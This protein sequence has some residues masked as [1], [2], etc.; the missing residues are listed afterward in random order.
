MPK[1]RTMDANRKTRGADPWP[2]DFKQM[3]QVHKE[4]AEA[5]E[6]RWKE[7]LRLGRDLQGRQGVNLGKVVAILRGAWFYAQQERIVKEALNRSDWTKR[8]EY[9][10]QLILDLGRAIAG[11]SDILKPAARLAALRF[12]PLAFQYC[13]DGAVTI[14]QAQAQFRENHRVAQAFGELYGALSEALAP[15]NERLARNRG[16]QPQPWIAEAMRELR[17]A[18]VPKGKA[19]ELL[20]ALRLKESK[21]DKSTPQTISR[22]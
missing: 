20:L 4:G 22:Q 13:D 15:I 1:R 10:H 11:L 18:G 7:L 16:H 19:D 12:R 8:T 14:R 5:I 6:L 9:I 3:L 17:A 21:A 2:A